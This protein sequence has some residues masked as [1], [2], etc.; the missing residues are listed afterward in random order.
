MN[1][2]KRCGVYICDDTE[3]CP[4]CKGVLENDGSKEQEHINI[5]PNIL[6]KDRTWNLILRI[7]LATW[8]V[9]TI[10]LVFINYQVP[11][12]VWWSVVASA[13]YFYALSVVRLL[14]HPYAGY[15]RRIFG[16]VFGAMILNLVID[17]CFGFHGWSLNYIFPA[18]LFFINFALI[19][20]MIINHRNWQSYMMLQ[21]FSIFIGGIPLLFIKWGWVTHPLLSEIAFLS[22]VV[23]FL[24]TLIVGGSAARNELK[25]RFYI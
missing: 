19:L 13:S 10:V 5:Y 23:L 6:R 4:L 11:H 14:T 7:L 25:R 20:L 9:G 22:S 1:K 2:C 18:A 15:L 17:Y 12:K 3:V 21:I 24:G 16:I 8:V